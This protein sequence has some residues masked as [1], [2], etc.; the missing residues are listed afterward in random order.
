MNGDTRL[1]QLSGGGGGRRR[2]RPQ[3]VC[4][5]ALPRTKGLALGQSTE[6]ANH[7]KESSKFK[8][9]CTICRPWQLRQSDSDAVEMVENC[10]K[11]REAADG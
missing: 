7:S 8:G 2:S 11:R 5:P 9:D 1:D 3:E 10:L 4:F 6:G